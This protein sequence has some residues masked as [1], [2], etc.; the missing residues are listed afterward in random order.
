MTDTANVISISGGKDSTSTALYAIDQGAENKTFIFADTGHEHPETYEYV[1][2][3]DG[4]LKQRAGVGITTVRAD[5]TDDMARKRDYIRKK[6]PEDGIPETQINEALEVLHPTGIPFLDLC[7][8]KGRFPSTKV[9]FCT[10]FLKQKPIDNQVVQPLM[11]QYGTVISWQGVR[12]DESKSR[13]NLPQKDVELGQWEPEPKGLL[14]YRPILH[15]TADDVFAYQ[16]QHQVL[17]NPLYKQGMGRVGCMPCI[18]ARKHELREIANRFPE[19][20]DKV[21]R[22][23]ELVT[24]T[25]KTPEATFFAANKTPGHT[26][27][28]LADD[29]GKT[30]GIRAVEE[31][32]KTD[33]GGR[34]F[35][36]VAAAEASEAAEGAAACSSIYG[37]CE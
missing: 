16:K 12:A 1:E 30:Y 20:F 13:A 3:L 28:E 4:V 35:D 14:V 15:W 17:P 18:H 9:R 33:H 11:D 26:R 7:L 37:L 22:W 25:A 29:P 34:Q 6:W 19:A 2:Y 23:E 10:E 8:L 24:K 21:E 27:G 31:W 36:L 32:A 5:L